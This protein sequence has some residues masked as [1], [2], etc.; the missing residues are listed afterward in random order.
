MFGWIAC[1]NDGMIH[2]SKN[3]LQFILKLC[4]SVETRIIRYYYDE[5]WTIYLSILLVQWC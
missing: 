1:Y 3:Q 4:S 2:K 5:Q